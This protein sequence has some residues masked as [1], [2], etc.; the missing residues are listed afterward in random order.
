[1]RSFWAI[2]IICLTVVCNS[3]YAAGG[4]EVTFMPDDPIQI[5]VPASE[6]GGSDIVAKAIMDTMKHTQLVPT[7]FI[8]VH[9]PGGSGSA[10]IAYANGRPDPNHTL[11]VANT[12]H[13][14]R[15]YANSHQMAL[16]PIVRLAEDPILL[17]VPADSEYTTFEEF[18]GGSHDHEIL[19]GTADILDRYCVLQLKREIEGDLRSVYY[20][21]A[22][23]IVDGMVYG[24]LDGGILNPSEARSGLESGNLRVLVAFSDIPQSKLIPKTETLSELGYNGLDLRFSR[25]VMGPQGMADDVVDYWSSIFSKMSQSSYWLQQ[26]ITPGDLQ[27]AFLDSQGTQ[28]FLVESELPW[29]DLILAEGLLD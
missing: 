19:I 5:V 12:S 10:A 4:Q 20:N 13:L 27:A 22:S 25:Y 3:L 26:Y 28:T 9:K 18:V 14:L 29:L 16:T 21:G 15:M 8:V 6:G 24:Q 7:P 17:V 2:A 23:F 1:M 11:F